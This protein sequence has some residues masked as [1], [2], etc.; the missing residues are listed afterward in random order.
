MRRAALF[1]IVIGS[2]LVPAGVGTAVGR[3][4]RG[5]RRTSSM[6]PSAMSASI[7]RAGTSR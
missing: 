5:R 3:S 2:L 1:A 7:V 4:S 6:S